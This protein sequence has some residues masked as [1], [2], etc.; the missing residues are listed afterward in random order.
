MACK[1]KEIDLLAVTAAQGNYPVDTT[2]RNARRIL[3]LI[4][5]EDVPVYRGCELPM[6]R[7]RP[8]DPFTHGE[9]GQCNTNLPDSSQP[10]ETKHA[11]NAMID[12]IRANPWR[13]NSDLPCPYDKFGDGHAPC[14]RHH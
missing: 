5:R 7:K 4:G 9:D 3:H 8:H 2:F 6:V 11:V 14:A 13:S 1:S 12:L 10:A